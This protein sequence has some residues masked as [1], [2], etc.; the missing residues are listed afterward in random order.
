MESDLQRYKADFFKAMAHPQRLAL[1]ERLVSGPGTVT[2]LAESVGLDVPN[3]SRHL[4]QLKQA[5]V[6][7]AKREG[8]TISYR[9]SSP[10]VAELLRVS[11]AILKERLDS[12]GAMLADLGE[13]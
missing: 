6:V 10:Q 2:E 3:A 11:R 7:D 9:L 13:P 5:G 4:A 8:Q 1:L 12:T